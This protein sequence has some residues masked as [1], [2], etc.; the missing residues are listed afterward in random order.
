VLEEQLP[1]VYDAREVNKTRRDLCVLLEK[2]ETFWRQRSQVAWLK[3]GD[4]NT[5]YF[6]ECASERKRK[7]NTIH[8]LLDSSNVWQDDPGE[9]E[10][11]AVEYFQQIYTSS[12]PSAIDNVTQLVSPAVTPDMN[13]N[14]L[15]PFSSE[16][17]KFTFFQMRPSKAPGPDG[18]TFFFFFF[19][20]ILAY[21]GVGCY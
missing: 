17:I 20:K 21:Y 10:S 18:M 5:R 3:D 7:M 4:Q 15:L 16:E 1:V 6:H 14:L 12:N 9:V 19:P 8:G 2:E 11:I 13:V